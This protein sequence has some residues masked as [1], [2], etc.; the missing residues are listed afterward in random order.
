M[1]YNRRRKN[2]NRLPKNEK[3]LLETET[4]RRKSGCS[5]PQESSLQI[6]QRKMH[7]AERRNEML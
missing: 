1:C 5:L 4:Y 7:K 6:F 3:E 2:E